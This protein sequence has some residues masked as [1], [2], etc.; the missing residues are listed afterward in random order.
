MARA[1]PA[2]H[3]RDVMVEIVGALLVRDGEVLLGRRA[4]WKSMLPNC[5]DVIGGHVEQG[6]T[7]YETLV[8]EVAEEV[9]VRVT[10]A[11]SMGLVTYQLP[12]R[13]PLVQALFHV[14]AWD[15]EPVLTNDEH[16]ELRWFTRVA[17]ADIGDEGFREYRP[18]LEGLLTS[19]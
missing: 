5:W 4:A 3:R 7:P 19:P 9:G 1:D 16:T 6:E 13:G 15:G 11:E 10:A 18:L 17:L 8:R 14:S 2:L 12:G